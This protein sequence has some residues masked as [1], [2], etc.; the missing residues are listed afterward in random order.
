MKNISVFA[1]LLAA[2]MLLSSCGSTYQIT[3]DG[4]EDQTG[5]EESAQKPDSLPLPSQSTSEALLENM[6]DTLPEIFDLPQ[7]KA[8]FVGFSADL[9]YFVADFNQ[10]PLTEKYGELGS[11]LFMLDE[12]ISDEELATVRETLQKQ[13]LLEK[14]FDTEGAKELL[15]EALKAQKE[16]IDLEKLLLSFTEKADELLSLPAYYKLVEAPVEGYPLRSPVKTSDEPAEKYST[17]WLE[18]LLNQ[19]A[20]K[21]YPMVYSGG[22]YDRVF[23]SPELEASA[24]E[25]WP[26]DVGG[27]QITENTHFHLNMYMDQSEFDGTVDLGLENYAYTWKIFYREA[28]STQE[29]RS[30][31]CT[32][33]SAITYGYN[34]FYRLD[35]YSAGMTDLKLKEDGSA[36]TYHMIFIIFN[37]EGEQVIWRDEMVKWTASSQKFLSKAIEHGVVEGTAPVD[38]CPEIEPEP[39]LV[40][41]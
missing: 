24:W 20:G 22:L 16:D 19:D 15:V 4:W 11:Y 23:Y 3:M 25:L 14:L 31:T 34:F 40:Y 32:P 30:V 21:A 1:L 39:G 5:K 13:G 6:P 36:N 2:L 27:D 38:P 35:L 29:Y 8:D 26:Y 12:S 18:W 41:P 10:T 28:D 17:E 9:R 33:W 7:Y 37:E